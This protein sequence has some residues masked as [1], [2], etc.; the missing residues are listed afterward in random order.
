MTDYPLQGAHLAVPCNLCHQKNYRN[1]IRFK[2][3]TTTCIA[4]HRDFHNGTASI[5]V[6]N[7]RQGDECSY[8]HSS[9]SWDAV[10]FDHTKTEFPL[11]GKHSTILCGK[12]HRAGPDKAGES[13]INF[14]IGSKVCQD[15]HQDIHGGQ[16]ARQGKTDC[17]GCHTETDWQS[18]KFD[19]N[20]DSQFELKGA[21]QKVACAKCHKNTV[22]G[23]EN[24]IL[25]KP[26]DTSCSACHVKRNMEGR[27]QEL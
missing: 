24:T 17:Q 15:C 2:F 5:Y 8:C 14:K 7:E 9:E 19:H 12:C 11:K 23:G 3:N 1:T 18:S 10:N 4:C 6:S 22:I 25:Y 26:I 20:R 13:A 27:G 21:H 16:F